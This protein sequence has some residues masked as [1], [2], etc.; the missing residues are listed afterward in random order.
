MI[1]CICAVAAVCALG[2][3]SRNIATFDLSKTCLPPR[4]RNTSAG[5]GRL[6]SC[7][8]AKS[9]GATTTSPALTGRPARAP[10]I[11]SAMVRPKAEI[12]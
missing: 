1:R 10:N 8:K 12:P 9:T 7:E 2:A 5:C 4:V 6:P 3:W 11:F